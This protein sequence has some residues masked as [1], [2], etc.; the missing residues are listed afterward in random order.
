MKIVQDGLIAVYELVMS[1]I[2]I[3]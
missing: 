1:V 3:F 2:R